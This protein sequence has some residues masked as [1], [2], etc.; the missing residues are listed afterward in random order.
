MKHRYLMHRFMPYV[1]AYKGELVIGLVLMLGMVVLDLVQPWPLKILLDNV[2]GQR[3]LPKFL[4]P[5]TGGLD[6]FGLLLFVC[7]SVI[8]IAVLDGTVTYFG[9]SHVKN[10]GQRVIFNIRRD[11][12]S[13]IQG[14][15]LSFH[16]KRSTGDLIARLTSDV[17]LVQEMV[18]SSLFVLITNILTLAGM[19]VVML[20]IDWRLTLFAIGIMP[21]LFYVIYHYTRR[22]KQL[23]RDQRKREGYIASLAQETISSIRIVQAYAAEERAISRFAETSRL[24]L[25]SSLFSTRLQASFVSVVGLCIAVG[26]SVIM[27][28]GA[29]SVHAG[30]LTPGDLIVFL[31]YLVAMY[32]PMRNLSKLSNTLTKATAAAERIVEILDTHSDVHDSPDAK[33]IA[34][35]QG[36]VEFEHVDFYYDPAHPVLRDINLVAKPGE[37]IAIVGP[38]GAGKSTLMAL[39]LRFYDPK[40]GCVRM[41]GINLQSLRLVSVRRNVSIV[42]QEAVLFRTTIRQNI[43]YA[44]PDA[45]QEEIIAAAK[46]AQ[47]HEFILRLPL[48]YDTTVGERG[49]T[50]SGG[51][52][53]RIAIARAILKNAPIVVLDEPTTGLDAESEALVLRALEELTRDRTT[54]IITHRLSI[55]QNASKILVMEQGQIVE[56]GT[57]EELL[58]LR[59]RYRDIYSIH[60]LTQT[61]HAQVL[62]EIQE[63]KK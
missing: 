43:A 10:L 44:R 49:S 28:L 29:T 22:I 63:V 2:I 14:L 30:R 18:L 40:A 39:L 24:S 57:H 31:A 58:M 54:F 61:E 42:L 52:R 53:Q 26:T 34:L 6:W 59:G 32:R 17:Q 8:G 46:A 47:A 62:A 3:R 27:Y 37:K 7:I 55:V 36:F 50:L 15:S 60:A 25:E 20:I 9:E 48:G 51:E 13:H 21:L 23:S 5:I 35:V 33:D 38:T 4:Q 45:T 1:M 41:D 16:D 56:S 12:Y 19:L 11:L